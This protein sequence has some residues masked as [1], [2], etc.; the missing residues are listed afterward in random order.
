MFYDN[1]KENK[2]NYKDY[3]ILF[4]TSGLVKFIGIVKSYNQEKGE[5][6]LSEV[7]KLIQPITTK[8]I[9]NNVR[10]KYNN[11]PQKQE[12]YLEDEPVRFK[13][14]IEKNILKYGC[15]VYK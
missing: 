15:E 1:T 8:D 7:I 2:Y 10:P 3:G 14:L 6:L 11:A 13:K 5:L 12:F 4:V 9:R